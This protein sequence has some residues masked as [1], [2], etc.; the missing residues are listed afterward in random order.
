MTMA[1]AVTA[2]ETVLSKKKLVRADAD[3][4]VGAT[5][6]TRA[7]S[8]HLQIFRRRLAA[9]GHQLV[10]DALALIERAQTRAFDRRDMNKNILSA[11]G[12]LN[13]AVAFGRVEPLHVSGRHPASPDLCRA[14]A[15]EC[16]FA[17]IFAR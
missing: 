1:A 12:R 4:S 14:E 2:S 17:R 9:V 3:Q 8:C 15:G 11:I 7:Q 6:A 13:E 5:R 10:L 16:A